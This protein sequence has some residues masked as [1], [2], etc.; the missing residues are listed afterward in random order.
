MNAEREKA[1]AERQ[2]Y[3]RQRSLGTVVKESS[4]IGGLWLRLAK[5][6]QA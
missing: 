4:P 6:D 3:P 2:D 5:K 1:P